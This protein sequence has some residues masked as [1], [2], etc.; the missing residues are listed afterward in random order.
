MTNICYSIAGK[1]VEVEAGRCVEV[2]R[3]L[4]GFDVFEIKPCKADLK[5]SMDCALALPHIKPVH[6]FD[7]AEGG[8][9]CAFYAET[10]VHWF[11]MENGSG[12]HY[13]LRYEGGNEVQT[14]FIDDPA[15][16]RFILW[17]AMA[18]YGGTRDTAPVHAACVCQGGRGYL[19]LGE[20]GT[21]KST[22]ASL[23]LRH[24]EG[25]TLLNDDSPIVTVNTA[26]PMVYGS[27]WSG[28]TPCFHNQGLPIGGIVRLHQAQV[29][30]I[31]RLGTLRALAAVEPSLPPALRY[32]TVYADGRM[33]MA[34][35]LI[36]SVNVFSMNCL[37]NEDAARMCFDACAAML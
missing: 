27:P 33:S 5:V 10:G 28:K 19:F 9:R 24:I 18:M 15:A 16:L 25:S 22:H 11:V 6:T 35:R 20:S 34:S 13:I 8:Y 36:G 2:L 23:W 37:P 17:M 31:E 3:A 32:D 12:G 26:V 1:T 21:G 30:S 4:P 29:N 14:T 7:F